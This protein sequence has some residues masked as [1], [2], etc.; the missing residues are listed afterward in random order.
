AELLAEKL[1]NPDAA[2][3][4]LTEVRK[5]Q[6][7]WVPALKM[8]STLY[9]KMERWD[10][11]LKTYERELEGQPDRDQAIFLLEK[12]AQVVEDKLDDANR[13]VDVYKRMLSTQSGYLPAL[14]SLGR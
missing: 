7:G 6:P 13:A 14:R 2:L 1:A 8:A 11:L 3:L 9:A 12:M 10:D 5:L 4:R